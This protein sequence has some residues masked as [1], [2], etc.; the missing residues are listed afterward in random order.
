[1]TNAARSLRTLARVAVG[2]SLVAVL[3]WTTML[4]FEHTNTG[5]V[6]DWRYIAA[7]R[8][9]AIETRSIDLWYRNLEA[10]LIE[11]NAGSMVV[12]KRCVDGRLAEIWPTGQVVRH[13][14]DRSQCFRFATDTLLGFKERAL[15]PSY[16]LSATDNA[17]DPGLAYDSVD[18]SSPIEQITL[19]PDSELP[20][21]AR[22]RS[23]EI[24]TW[25]YSRIADGGEAPPAARPDAVPGV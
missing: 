14:A 20:L 18:P 7:T 21:R 16:A 10:V 3:G 22:F 4:I 2:A 6:R 17:G 25:E 1:M 24:W 8:S 5:A 15:S 19:D 23:G 12:E 11:R 13:L 9:D